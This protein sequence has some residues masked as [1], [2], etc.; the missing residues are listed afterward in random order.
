M[1]ERA[2]TELPPDLKQLVRCVISRLVFDNRDL[3]LTIISPLCISIAAWA[4]APLFRRGK[5]LPAP[6]PDLRQSGWPSGPRVVR[7]LGR[8]RED[9]A[10]EWEA[11]K[12]RWHEEAAMPEALLLAFMPRELWPVIAHIIVEGPELSSKRLASAMD[13]MEV[14]RIKPTKARPSGGTLSPGTLSFRRELVNRVFLTIVGL[15]ADGYESTCLAVW[16]HVPKR[17]AV[18]VGHQVVT[19]R[20]APSRRLCRLVFAAYRADVLRRLR[21]DT[22]EELPQRV[23]AMTPGQLRDSSVAWSLRI[24]AM[25]VVMLTTGTRRHA[26]LRIR[27][28]DFQSQRTCWD[29][30]PRPAVGVRPG[31]GK[32]WDQLFFKPIPL[33]AGRIIEAWAGL[34]AALSHEPLSPDDPLF[35]ATMTQ[36]HQETSPSVMTIQ[37]SGYFKRGVGDGP[38]RRAAFPRYIDTVAFIGRYRG[39]YSDRQCTRYSPHAL[40]HAADQLVEH[41][42]PRYLA[43]LGEHRISGSI[44]VK[45]MCNHSMTEDPML[46]KDFA[47]PQGL[48]R[49]CCIGSEIAWAVLTSDAGARVVLD[50]ARIEAAMRTRA[51]LE[52]E[53]ETIR[54]R[55]GAARIRVE[56]VVNADPRSTTHE[57]WLRAHNLRS[58][59]D[60]MGDERSEVQAALR[61]VDRELADLQHDEARK[62]AVPDEIDDS[63]LVVDV[64]ALQLTIDGTTTIKGSRR[65][66][67]RRWL[68]PAEFAHVAGVSESEVKRWLAG[69]FSSRHRGPLP[70]PP[71]AV[72][73]EWISTRRRRILVDGVNPEFVADP[74]CAERLE[75]LLAQ[76]GKDADR[77]GAG[78]LA[79]RTPAD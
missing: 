17:A 31:K 41:G 26:L 19:D 13:L 73:V 79:A 51:A 64:A 68:T 72:P 36:P 9:L 75:T 39:P 33:P 23:G 6:F 20:T 52:A 22:V 56:R 29:G 67:R 4:R 2:W 32:P 54:D 1:D 66:R 69:V 42:A 61:D 24:L 44:I 25:L 78:G 34:V 14:T 16:T 43:D 60:M 7:E 47:N 37:F 35:P 74:D 59:I 38:R 48:E 65:R 27:R 3:R 12:Q 70:W 8:S 15:R 62:V 55:I 40:R 57:D 11:T 63:E 77:A 28:G 5:E 76:L 45:A 71:D 21:C 58:S 18:S 30:I 10:F 50:R 49:L 46:Y 53:L